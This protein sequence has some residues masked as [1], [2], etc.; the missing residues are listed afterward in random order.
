MS[1]GGGLMPT[2]RMVA[3]DETSDLPGMAAR[4]GFDDPLDV[5]VERMRPIAA[6][7]VDGLQVAAALEASGITD[8]AARVEFGFADVFDLAG[9]V[10]RRVAPA[11]EPPRRRPG[12]IWAAELR[13][14]GHGAMYLLPAALFP[15]ALAAL[16]RDASVLGIVLAAAIGWVW[17]GATAWLGYQ[18]LGQ[19]RPVAAARLLRWSLFSVLPAAGAAGAIVAAVTGL[20]YGVVV[21][22]IIQVAYQMACTV[23][24]FYHREGLIVATMMPAV[25]AGIAFIT[26]GLTVLPFAV[27]VGIASVIGAVVLA[28]W[29]T[30]QQS[31]AEEPP[32][33]ECLSGKLRPFL[34][35]L[36]FTA[37]SAT[38]FLYP[39]ARHFHD[40]YVAVAA[41]PVIV[42]M[43][44]VEWR[45]RRFGD[46]ARALLARVAHP[47]QFGLRVWLLVL[48]GLG[49]CLLVVSILA[50]VLL[51]LFLR[52]GQLTPAVTAMAAAS[53]LLSG[54][55]YLGFILAN[56]ARYSWLCGS[57]LLCLGLYL[58]AGPSVV[59]ALTDTGALLSATA[60][61]VLLY[62][63]ALASCVH[64]AYRHR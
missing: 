53:V 45:A 51:A 44:V 23:L 2:A 50:A 9:E 64:E 18:F 36:A 17:S 11:P 63:A 29:K 62:L 16:G 58:A 34:P 59:G 4:L 49:T 61:L 39:Q 12:R 19:H 26:A 41:L 21:M 32:L 22:A 46:E 57:L 42:G 37:L 6:R 40:G 55:Y 30:L 15:P 27:A 31:G 47:K 20:G 13:D 43:G 48:S 35:V 14:I 8:R 1:P 5:L 52:S 24:V 10:H 25:A 7:S 60:L 28:V 38:F 3:L 33:K 56:S 54:A